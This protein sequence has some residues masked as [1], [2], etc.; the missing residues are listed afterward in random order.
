MSVF[1]EG[2]AR[3]SL[4]ADGLE[5]IGEV[6][7]MLARTLPASPALMIDAEREDHAEQLRRMFAENSDFVW[8]SLRHLGIA[9]AD[10]EDVVQ[11]VFVVVHKRLC[12]YEERSALR[13][14]LYAICLRVCSRHRRSRRRR[15]EDTLA[16]LP[17]VGVEPEQEHDVERNEAL[18]LG[19]QLIDALPDKQRVVFLMYELEHMTMQEIAEILGCPIQT[20]YARLHR[21]RE[22]VRADLNRQR[23][24]VG[25]SRL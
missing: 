17:D 12:D 16:E 9:P 25:R 11:E 5:G 15:P 19:R 20:A 1:G 18:R 2:S 6:R 3:I 4:I 22:N 13:S 14:W 23:M 21:A 7:N 24:F 8:R 10:I